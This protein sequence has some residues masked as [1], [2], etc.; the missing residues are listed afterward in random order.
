MTTKIKSGVIGD[1]VVGTTQIA[2]DAI[3]SAKIADNAVG[4]S[5]LNLSDGTNGQVLTTDGSG[6]LSFADAAGGVDG[7]VSSA[8]ATAITIDSSERVLIG[9]TAAV[10]I[11]TIEQRV[12][13]SGVNQAT[14]GLS[15]ARY[16]NGAFAPGIHLAKSRNATVGSHTIIQDGDRLGDINFYGSDGTDF[17]N[18][19]AT[20]MCEVDGTP[21]NDDT[22]GRLT[23]HTTADGSGAATERMRIDNTGNV[24]IGSGTPV[25][26]LDVLAGSSGG[27]RIKQSNQITNGF[28][29][30]LEDFRRGLS[31]ENAGSNHAFSVG[32]GQ[33]GHLRI[34]YYD[35]GSTYTELAEFKNSGNLNITDGDIELASGHGI[36]FAAT[37]NSSGSMSNELLDDYEEG[38]WTPALYTYSGVTTTSISTYGIYTKIGNICHIHA[39]IAATLSSLPGQTFTIT[40]LPFT[41]TNSS[42]TGQR[43]IITIGGDTANLGGN[44]I[45]KAHFRTNG[46]DLQGVYLNSGTTAYWTYNTMDSSSFELNI[47]GFYTT[48]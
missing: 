7:I 10:P 37:A 8:D 48:T 17:S 38:T 35:A 5:A 15:L 16:Q 4:I 20:I 44:A 24:R 11:R 23:F 27:A 41:A 31:F 30:G 25:V 32:Y 26:S 28:V 3:S 46:T 34:S 18:H 43:A 40:G 6:T 21:G 33:G 39:K 45:G 19:A 2:D 36:S 13:I 29:G 1:G 9:H 12:Q 42:D 22:P 47:H 14:A